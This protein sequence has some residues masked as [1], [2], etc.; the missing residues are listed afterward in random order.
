MRVR[1]FSLDPDGEDEGGAP[2]YRLDGEGDVEGHAA[3]FKGFSQD[4]HDA[5]GH[6]VR[7]GRFSVEADRRGGRR[8]PGS[9]KPTPR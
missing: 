2:L 4:E 6:A 7:W 8:R 3:R 1:Y 9:A 5:E